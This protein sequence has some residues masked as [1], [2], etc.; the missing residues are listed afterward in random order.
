M[1][2]GT[3]AM[4]TQSLERIG[5]FHRYSLRNVMLIASQKPTTS[6]T[7]ELVINARVG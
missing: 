7:E 2:E 6:I 3:S 4:L 5:R 1:R